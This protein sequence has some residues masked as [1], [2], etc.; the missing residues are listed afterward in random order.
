MTIDFNGSK[1]VYTSELKC[2]KCGDIKFT[3]AYG[4][5]PALPMENKNVGS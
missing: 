5:Q 2:E 3:E 1:S 4:K